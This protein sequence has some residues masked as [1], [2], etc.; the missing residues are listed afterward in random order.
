MTAGVTDSFL[1][2]WHIKMLQA[3]HACFP[4]TLSQPFLQGETTIWALVMLIAAGSVNI[5]RSFQGQEMHCL[6]ENTL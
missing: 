5:S 1:A 2:F 3:Y 6:R 4:Q